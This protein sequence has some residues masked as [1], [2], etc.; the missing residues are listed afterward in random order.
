MRELINL[1][2]LP[3]EMFVEKEVTIVLD[4]ND[5]DKHL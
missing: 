3:K 1:L 4:S 2:S 5:T